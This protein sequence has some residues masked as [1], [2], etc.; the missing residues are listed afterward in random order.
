MV[1]YNT[2]LGRR[3]G[4]A[5]L[6]GCV[7]IICVWIEVLD[8]IEQIAILFTNNLEEGQC[9]ANDTSSKGMRSRWQGSESTSLLVLIEQR[10]VSKHKSLGSE[11]DCF[12]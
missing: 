3:W 9:F 6:V 2:A 11:M 12:M 8:R 5:G 1:W 7:Y 4:W 10:H